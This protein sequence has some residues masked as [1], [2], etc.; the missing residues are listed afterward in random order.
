MGTL[1]RLSSWSTGSLK[2]SEGLGSNRHLV[3]I[4]L[5]SVGHDAN[6]PEGN[7]VDL[8]GLTDGIGALVEQILIGFAAQDGD[9]RSGTDVAFGD[10]AVS[11]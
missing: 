10:S 1:A 8:D 2:A 9:T 7:A 6:H 4:D 11:Q 5:A 3:Q